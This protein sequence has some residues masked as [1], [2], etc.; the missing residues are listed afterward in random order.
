MKPYVLAKNGIG[1][2]MIAVFSL[3]L[4]ASADSLKEQQAGK[5]LVRPKSLQT[6]QLTTG[7][8]DSALRVTV[9]PYGT[10]GSS[11]YGG[12]AYYNPVGSGDEAGTVFESAVYFSLFGFL[13]SGD[14][15]GPAL[16]N[17]AGFTS[18]NA[19]TAVSQF[20]VA[21]FSV[22][23]TQAVVRRSAGS[24]LTQTYVFKN[25]SWLSQTFYLMR[26]VDGD[27]HFDGTIDDLAKVVRNGDLMYEFD[28]GDDPSQPVTFFAIETDGGSKAG[29]RAAKYR[30]TDDIIANGAGVLTS[31]VDGDT[32][33]DGM[34]DTAGDWTMTMG[35]QFT[36]ASGGSITFVTT[37]SWGEGAPNSD[38]L[39]GVGPVIK[40]NGVTN[41][42]IVNY[43][44]NVSITVELNP[45]DYRG[46]GV[47]WWIV[48][49]ANVEGGG[50]WYYLV[51]Q[52]WTEFHGDLSYTRPVYQGPL[53][54]LQSTPA[55]DYALKVPGI[56]YFWFAVSY[57][58]DGKLDLNSDTYLSQCV[59]VVVK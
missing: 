11:T 55:L 12:E 45:G 50:S 33:G 36:V 51:G 31:V 21:D 17:D 39:R 5:N 2:I 25:N 24:Y 10:F 18:T 8:G 30:F 40:A 6:A 29:Y 22:Q 28:S 4:I 41:N 23:L 13:H 49:H 48:A 43:Q 19:S 58:M 42:I 57:P 3:A 14:I 7:T 27:L 46:V 16:S 32:N 37:T 52:Q 15:D 54:E 1:W 20:T 53:D 35:R 56:Y 38:P 47:D 9:T 59:T 34:T 44:E 26:H